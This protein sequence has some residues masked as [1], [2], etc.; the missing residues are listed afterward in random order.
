[1]LLVTEIMFAT[2]QAK[3]LVSLPIGAP[4]SKT[5]QLSVGIPKH[6]AHLM[7]WKIIFSLFILKYYGFAKAL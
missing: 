1:M 7:S 6:K 5:L 2:M 4:S 3:G